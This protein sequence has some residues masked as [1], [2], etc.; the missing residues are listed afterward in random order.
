MASKSEET[1]ACLMRD[2]CWS[3]WHRGLP[4]FI[5]ERNNRVIAVEVKSFPGQKLSQEQVTVLH[6]LADR[7]LECYRWD[8]QTHFQTIYGMAP[9]KGHE[10][11]TNKARHEPQ[12]EAVIRRKL[13]E[14][15][16]N[17]PELQK[18]DIERFCLTRPRK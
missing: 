11:F 2:A 8:P 17:L 18:G 13:K 12:I 10:P 7:G 9:P 14:A 16:S 4:D 6:I 15:E 3:V 1:F 5:C